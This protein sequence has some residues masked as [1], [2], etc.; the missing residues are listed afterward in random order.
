MDLEEADTLT[1]FSVSALFIIFLRLCGIR[2][3]FYEGLF[4]IICHKITYSVVIY[5]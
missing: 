5:M 2:S 3:L 4:A 1:Q